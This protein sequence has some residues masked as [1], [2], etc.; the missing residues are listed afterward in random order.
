MG[1]KFS[2]FLGVFLLC[3]AACQ[4]AEADVPGSA[5]SANRSDIGD[6]SVHPIDTAGQEIATRFNTPYGFTRVELPEQ[7]FGTY[8]RKLPLKPEGSPVFLHNGSQKWNQ[9]AHAAVVNLDVGSR[10]LQQCADAVMRLRAEYLW[11]L[12]SYNDIHFNFTNGFP[13][14]YQRWRN[15]ERISV[16]GNDVRWVNRNRPDHSYEGFRRY[17][18]MVFAYA[19]TLSLADEL[20]PKAI[21]DIAVGDV[22]IQGGSPGHAVIVVDKAINE[23]SGEIIVLLAQSYMPAQDIHVLKNP[24]RSDPWYLI[25]AETQSIRTPE[26]SFT[27]Q[28][29]KRF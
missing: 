22:L 4:S 6:Q 20:E 21:V 12:E 28:D 23:V 10:D 8:L 1:A 15:G 14:P 24:S 27:A 16:D 9:N 13:A 25:S 17:L 29:L 18:N 7:S 5:G 11:Q 2:L 3:C 19:G 26:W